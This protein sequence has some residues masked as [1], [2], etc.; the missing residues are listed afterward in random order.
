MIKYHE[1]DRIDWLSLFNHPFVTGEEE[2]R[3]GL[4]FGT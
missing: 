1:E 4:Q 3:I 2:N